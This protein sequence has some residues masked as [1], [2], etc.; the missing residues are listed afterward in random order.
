MWSA[1]TAGTALV[2]GWMVL[3][4]A[5]PAATVVQP[6]PVTSV[7]WLIL[8]D[9][10][11]ADFR[12]TG[13]LRRAL[14]IV[15]DEALE[16]DDRYALAIAGPDA[17]TTPLTGDRAPLTGLGRTV[18]GNGL[19]VRD[20]ADD[21]RRRYARA[22][23]ESRLRTLATLEALRDLVAM[24]RPGSHPAVLVALTQGLVLTA[25]ETIAAPALSQA[26]ART[27]EA[28]PEIRAAYD[29]VMYEAVQRGVRVV[30][31]DPRDPAVAN[32][33]DP[34]FDAG[35]QV[36]HRALERASL[37]DL[38]GRTG[39]T[40]VEGTADLATSLVAVRTAIRP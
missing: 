18:T 32:A 9:E 6:S 24:A 22:G 40:A 12:Q 16:P 35:V 3:S 26:L 28:A 4:S 2:I 23:H 21:L 37:A 15:A 11:H 10:V 5:P 14:R 30:A 25:P 7:D 29:M 13:A 17:R 39:G 34:S 33:L 36:D 1:P 31:V 19:K 38:A 20:V 27:R 8:V